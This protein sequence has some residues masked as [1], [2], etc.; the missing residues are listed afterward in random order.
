MV[1]IVEPLGS[2]MDLHVQIEGGQRLVCR[3]PTEPIADDNRVTLHVDLAETHLF[4]G[5]DVA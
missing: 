2:L 5:N 4:V 1:E 3:V